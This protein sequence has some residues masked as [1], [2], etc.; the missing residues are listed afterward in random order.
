[1]RNKIISRVRGVGLQKK[2]SPTIRE[3]IFKPFGLCRRYLAQFE[4]NREI[5]DRKA[6]CKKWSPGKDP[7]FD[8]LVFEHGNLEKR[9][10]QQLITKIL[11]SKRSARGVSC[12]RVMSKVG[13]EG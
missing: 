1:M 2:L 11:L 4:M 7:S 9:S 13:Y 6:H 3:K 5:S 12:K 8:S 10:I